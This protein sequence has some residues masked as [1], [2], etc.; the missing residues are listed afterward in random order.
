MLVL[1]TLT[2][3]P[4]R[5][6]DP[7]GQPL[8]FVSAAEGFVALSAFMAGW[9]YSELARRRG[10][11]AMWRAFQL[12]AAKI[13]L[14]HVGLLLFLFTVIAALGLRV[15]QSAIKDLIAFFLDDPWVGLRT[16][17]LLLY[18][19]PLLDI[20]PLYVLFMLLS[21]AV[22]ALAMQ[23]G[24]RA[25]MAA[26]LALWL[27]AQFGLGQEL[28]ELVAAPSRLKVPLE[29]TG[30]FD[31]LAWQFLWMFGLCAG[32]AGADTAAPA[33]RWLVRM[34]LTVALIGFAWRHVQGQTPFAHWIGLN[35]LFDKWQLGPLRLVNFLALLVLLLHWGPA[36][37]RWRP[38]WPVLE[39]LG[40]ASLPVFCTHLVMVLLALALFGASRPERPLALDAALLVATFAALWAVARAVQLHDGERQ[41]PLVSGSAR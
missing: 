2:H 39:T 36:V 23:F 5:L 8:G 11:R 32:A 15:D 10:K 6:S 7:A 14:C 4:T 28:Y 31:P 9:V 17:L 25:L 3:L 19:P 13:Y 41:A 37:L 30:A 27:G 40:A 34:A 33:P 29:Q 1:M 35:A 18:N 16:G 38:R 21:P 22:L 24:W 20:L 12:R 26:S